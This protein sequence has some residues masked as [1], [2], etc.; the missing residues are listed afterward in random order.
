MEEVFSNQR[1]GT[2]S[3]TEGEEFEPVCESQNRPVGAPPDFF[4]AACLGEDLGLSGLIAF[5]R[6]KW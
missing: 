3:S 5:G 2:I 6:G 4:V 1:V